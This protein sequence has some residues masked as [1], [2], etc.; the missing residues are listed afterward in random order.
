MSHTQHQFCRGKKPANRNW[1]WQLTTG[2]FMGQSTLAN[3]RKQLGTAGSSSRAENSRVESW[4]SWESRVENARGGGQETGKLW[5]TPEAGRRQCECFATT[6]TSPEQQIQ[7]ELGD[8]GTAIEICFADWRRMLWF[9]LRYLVPKY[10]QQLLATTT[11]MVMMKMSLMMRLLVG[12]VSCKFVWN[13]FWEGNETAT[14]SFV[15]EF[16]IN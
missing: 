4:E 6:T 8:S 15:P 16:P 2:N 7:Q 12:A 14:T 3:E 13:L 11:T 10:N 5:G 9:R 1:N